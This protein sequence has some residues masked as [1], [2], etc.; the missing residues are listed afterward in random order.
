MNIRVA[1]RQG[2]LPRISE[3]SAAAAA[4]AAAQLVQAGAERGCRD[5][6]LP[7]KQTQLALSLLKDGIEGVLVKAPSTVSKDA[8]IVQRILKSPL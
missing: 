1:A 7:P 2:V 4:A 5:F 8:C 6:G 3:S